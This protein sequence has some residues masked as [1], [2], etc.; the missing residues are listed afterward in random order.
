MDLP[1]EYKICA[2]EHA[3]SIT[4]IEN[5]DF[6]VDHF[7][8]LTELPVAFLQAD[9]E[10]PPAEVL[11]LYREHN[12]DDEEMLASWRDDQRAGLIILGRSAN[13]LVERFPSAPAKLAVRGRDLHR[14]RD[15]LAKREQDGTQVG[16]SPRHGIRSG[17]GLEA[18]VERPRPRIPVSRRMPDRSP[19]GE[20][21][22]EAMIATRMLSRSRA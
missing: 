13:W 17:S 19:V 11:K 22:C 8:M 2:R 12:T 15:L 4:R 3:A 20:L 21:R 16:G 1:P 18:L 14:I 7:E 6:I 5:G 10:A 9:T